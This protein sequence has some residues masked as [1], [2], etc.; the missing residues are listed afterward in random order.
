M[1]ATI[2]NDHATPESHNLLMQNRLEVI[3]VTEGVT[4]VEP[5]DHLDQ[6]L[7]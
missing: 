1:D 4:L 6:G 7:P 5:G 2:V 3:W